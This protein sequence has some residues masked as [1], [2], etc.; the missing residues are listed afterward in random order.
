MTSRNDWVYHLLHYSLKELRRRQGITQRQIV[1]AYK[2][3]NISLL[4]ELNNMADSLTEAID[5][6]VF[7]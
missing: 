7:N 6:K 3:K 5:H 4:E 1:I 2:A